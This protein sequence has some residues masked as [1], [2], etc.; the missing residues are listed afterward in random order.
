MKFNAVVGNPPYQVKQ[1]SDNDS[2]N[3]SMA[4]AIY[5]I[6]VDL[7]INVK[8]NYVSLITPS[9]WMTKTGRGVSDTWVNEKI[10]CNHFI[11]LHDFTVATDCFDNV[12]IKGGVNYFLYSDKYN[13]MCDYTMHQNGIAVC[14]RNFLNSYGLGIVVRDSMAMN[15]LNKI[16][17]IEGQY[18]TTNNFADLVGPNTLFCDC[19]KGI[20]N[21]SWDGYVET[22]DEEHNIKYYLNKNRVKCGYAW[23]KPSDMIKSYD[24]VNIHKVYIP[25]AG[26]S[27]TDANVLGTPFYGEPGSICSQTYICIGYDTKK[28]NFSKI[29]CENIISYIKTKFFRYLVSIKKKTQ[30][31]FA[32]VYQFVPLQDFS[33]P[34]TDEEL[35]SKYNLD[36]FER[37]YIESLINPMD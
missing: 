14:Q 1:A 17:A 4:G 28:H 35:Y 9:R 21:T 31:A 6:F 23:I 12:E 32:Q 5:P 25:E 8:P 19:A 18:Y 27:G 13:D 34:W 37:E 16:I 2:A 15:I 10:N 20:L 33:K 36:M 11:T 22:R 30:H 26:G 3:S 24:V 29:E 7:A